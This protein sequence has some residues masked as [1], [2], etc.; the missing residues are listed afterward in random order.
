ML[1]TP[2]Y[3]TVLVLT[4][5]LAFEK[6]VWLI[7]MSSENPIGADNQ[8]ERPNI[9]GNPQRLYARNPQNI[10]HAVGFVVNDLEAAKKILKQKEI[11]LRAEFDYE[12]G[13]RLYFL[14]P[15]GIEVELVE[16][17]SA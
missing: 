12:P 16:Y 6:K 1:E 7:E 14:D 17:E 8:Q 9:V 13:K 2:V 15:D 5:D 10:N 11:P 3:P 4:V